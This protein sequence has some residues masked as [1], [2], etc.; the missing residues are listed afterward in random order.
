MNTA[1]ITAADSARQQRLLDLGELAFSTT[2]RRIDLRWPDQ[3]TL[4]RAALNDWAN[5]GPRNVLSLAGQLAPHS[6][7]LRAGASSATIDRFEDTVMP[8]L[9]RELVASWGTTAGDISAEPISVAD[10]TPKR[11]SAFLTVSEQL[12]HQTPIFVGQFLES[13]LLAA[14]A[15][16]ID[17]AA[18]VGTGSNG[19]PL[20]IL[21]DADVLQHELAVAGTLTLA[22]LASMQ[23]KIAD[24]HGEA[25]AADYTWL[26]AT[27][28][29]ETL[30]T[31][32]GINGPIWPTTSGPLGHRGEASPW[33]P[34]GSLILAQASKL[35]LVDWNRLTIESVT[36]RQQSIEGFRTLLVSGFFDFIVSDPNAVCVAVDP[37]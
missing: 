22:E 36:S 20:G 16:A 2:E 15:A 12:K 33:A 21:S 4:Q 14:V 24:A 35:V 5:D 37:A 32:A 1:L 19:E 9:N 10:A 26:A 29:R 31:T 11:L 25:A 6:A 3:S 30:Q 28:V 27:D 7:I 8:I 13:Q 23:K 18:L 17:K 34:D